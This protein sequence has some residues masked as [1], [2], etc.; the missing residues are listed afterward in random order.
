AGIHASA[1][2]KEPATYE[3]VP[4]EA[5]GN[6]RRVMVSDQ[7]GKANFLAELK[8]RGID[9]PK[10]DHRLDAL[11]SVVKEREAEGYAYE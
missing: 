3:H 5:V 8:R 2:A 7:G 11:I 6:R 1:L 10:D 9:M 4:P